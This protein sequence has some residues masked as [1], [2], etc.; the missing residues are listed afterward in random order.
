M[1]ERNA[2]SGQ[3]LMSIKNATQVCPS[4]GVQARIRS[5]MHAPWLRHTHAALTDAGLGMGSMLTLKEISLRRCSV[6]KQ[7][8]LTCIL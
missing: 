2:I 3:M 5:C 4:A 7:V 6:C 8:E 1:G